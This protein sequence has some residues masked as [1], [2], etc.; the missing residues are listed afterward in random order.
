[1]SRKYEAID[2][3]KLYSHGSSNGWNDALSKCHETHNIN[4]LGKLLYQIQAGMDDLAK[5]KLNTPAMNVWFA[6]LTK[7]IEKTAKLIIRE[8]HPSPADWPIIASK[9]RS[10]GREYKGVRYD[11]AL[12]A[13]RKR[14]EELRAFLKTNSY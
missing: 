8:R 11:D 7:S 4:R 13:K 3:M 5:K 12:V 10:S 14:D 9:M 1:M 2:L 6:R